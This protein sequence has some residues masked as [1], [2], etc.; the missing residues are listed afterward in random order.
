MF[1]GI[2]LKAVT[3]MNNLPLFIWSNREI[4]F[5]SFPI[6]INIWISNNS[7]LDIVIPKKVKKVFNKQMSSSHSTEIKPAA[8]SEEFTPKIELFRQYSISHV[9]SQ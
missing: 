5:R 9:T 8:S 7:S 4:S 6:P 3:E 1:W 2:I